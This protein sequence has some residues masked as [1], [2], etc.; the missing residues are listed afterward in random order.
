LSAE[1]CARAGKNVFQDL[2]PGSSRSSNCKSRNCCCQLADNVLTA[3]CLCSSCNIPTLP[4]IVV[5]FGNLDLDSFR[6]LPRFS[7]NMLLVAQKILE[8]RFN[9]LKLKNDDH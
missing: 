8:K 9:Y 4:V 3:P 6:D 1:L 7:F 2:N 5:L